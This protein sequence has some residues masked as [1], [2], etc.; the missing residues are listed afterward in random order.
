MHS[1]PL[2]AQKTTTRIDT[3]LGLALVMFFGVAFGFVFVDVAQNHWPV[4][5][6]LAADVQSAANDSTNS[7]TLTWT[8]PGDDGATGQA[9]RYDIRYSTQTITDGTWGSATVVANPPTPKVA[10][11]QESFQVTGLQPD[12]TYYF[13]LKTYDEAG[14]PSPLSNIA[15]RRTAVGSLLSCYESWHCTDWSACTNGTQT[16]S[17]SDANSCGTTNNRPALTYSC[18]P[19][20]TTAPEEPTTPVLQYP[21]AVG[22]SFFAYG[23]NLRGGFPSASGNL[24]G[25]GTDEVV[26][27]TDT[28]MAPQVRVFDQNGNAIHQFFAYDSHLRFGVNVATCD[29]NADGQDEIVTAQ[30]KGGWP[31]V[32]IFKADGTVV[33]NGF[34]VLDGKFKGG[35]FLS[36][37]DIDGNGVQEVVVAAARGGGAQIL[38]YDQT[39]RAWANFFAYDKSFRGGVRVTTADMDDDGKDEI[40][41]GPDLGAPHI[42]IF[43]IKT[44][45]I[46]RLSPGFFAFSRQYRGGVSVAGV[47]IDGDDK[48]ELVVGVGDNAQPL[49]KIYNIREQLI[50]QF[51]AFATAFLGGVNVSGGDTNGDGSEELI[52]TPRSGG[53]P[54]VRVIPVK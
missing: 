53:G 45:A 37:G 43:K 24:D 50:T 54:Q 38:V 52:V 48:K 49:V 42:Q 13:A 33:N 9:T 25:S 22:G 31:L 30:G 46:A 47:D 10:G 14:N 4:H 3:A 17:C 26:T 29:V 41:T 44:N 8:A 36:C 51:Y 39:G 20:S 6:V 23:T 18:T 40:I 5:H 16:R 19:G 27:G 28:G 21:E 12:T 35:V 34:Y 11:Q 7:V 2:I 1:T 32:K 15:S